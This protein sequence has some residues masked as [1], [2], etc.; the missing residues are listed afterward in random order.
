MLAEFFYGRLSAELVPGRPMLTLD[1]FHMLYAGDHCTLER[2]HSF[3]QWCFPIDVVS[4]F[5]KSATF[6]SECVARKLSQSPLAMMRLYY[7]FGMMLDF[8]G[9]FCRDE[10][11]SLKDPAR[12]RHLAMSQHNWLRVTRM[13]RSLTLFGLRP[14]S[15][16][17]LAALAIEVYDT[18]RLRSALVSYE[19]HWRAAVVEAGASWPETNCLTNLWRN[20]AECLRNVIT[21]LCRLACLSPGCIATAHCL[22]DHI[23]RDSRAYED[24]DDYGGLIAIG[25]AIG[26]PSLKR[27][28]CLGLR[29]CRVM[30]MVLRGEARVVSVPL[31]DIRAMRYASETS[32]R[33]VGGGHFGISVYRAIQRSLANAGSFQDCVVVAAAAAATVRFGDAP[34]KGSVCS[35][36][37]RDPVRGA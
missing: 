14:L 15:L 33:K 20:S 30:V 19:A 12:L 27:D 34:N 25:I 35:S 2:S 21:P 1:H 8:Y 37:I 10:H 4:R 9:F 16:A 28:Y 32:W 23:L 17:W 7:S 24:I 26:L 3:I 18:G 36:T 5:N 29:R 13:L 6:L 31:R 22:R 11:V